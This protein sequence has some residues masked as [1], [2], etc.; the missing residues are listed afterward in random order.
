MMLFRIN[1]SVSN[2][3]LGVL[4]FGVLFLFCLFFPVYSKSYGYKYPKYQWKN[5]WVILVFRIICIIIF[6]AMVNFRSNFGPTHTH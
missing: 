3:R 1:S 6:K 5:L 4:L 2:V